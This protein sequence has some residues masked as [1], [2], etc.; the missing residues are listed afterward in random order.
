[1]S[2]SRA[3]ESFFSVLGSI[4]TTGNISVDDAG[5]YEQ[6]HY[7]GL[8]ARSI[9]LPHRRNILPSQFEL[10]SIP[11]SPDLQVEESGIMDTYR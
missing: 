6:S 2:Y 4:R 11:W 3:R 8:C 1:M 10:P 7:P 9:R 5:S